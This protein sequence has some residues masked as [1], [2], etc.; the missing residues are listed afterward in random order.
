MAGGAAIMRAIPRVLALIVFSASGVNAQAEVSLYGGSLHVNNS[1]ITGNDPGGAGAFDFVGGWDSASLALPSQYGVRVTWWQNRVTGWGLDFNHSVIRADDSTLNDNG[2]GDLALIGGVNFLTLNAYRRWQDAGVVTPYVGA[3]VG[4]T[5]PRVEYQS[6]AGRTSEVQ[7]TGP[8]F[9][10][11]AGAS[12]PLS[13]RMSVFG[14]YKGS[15]SINS[16]DL[17]GGG[18][19]RANNLGSTVNI[20]VSLGF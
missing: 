16:A 10:W 8:A 9:Q 6:V 1:K 5:T 3:G 17:S 11:I 2:L 18:S 19:L 15:Y 12:Y 7:L 4:V 20:G 14:E 13:D